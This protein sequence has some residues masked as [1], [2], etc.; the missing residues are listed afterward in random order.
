MD[1]LGFFE[2]GRPRLREDET[3]H[4][5]RSTLDQVHLQRSHVS[6]LMLN[7]QKDAF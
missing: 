4:T 5:F 2:I 7:L 3:S 6:H 1:E